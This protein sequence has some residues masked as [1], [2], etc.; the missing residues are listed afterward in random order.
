MRKFLFVTFNNSQAY[1]G[2]S[3]C[4]KRNL[5]T[6]QDI[7][8]TEQIETYIIEPDK[9]NRQLAGTIK[10]AVGIMKGYLGGLT[11]K[12]LHEVL[13]MLTDG[14]FTDLFIDNSQL[15]ML[16]KYAKR[17]NPN[18]RIFTFFHNIEY[19]FFRSNVIHCKDYK[20]FFWIPLALKNE[21]MSCRYSDSII[22]LN[23]KDAKRLQLLYGRKADAI[24][25][26]T[27]K[28]DYTTPSQVQSIVTKGK[29]ALFVG[30]YF[31]GN[32]QGL[33]W[34][35][36]DILPHTDAHLT[37]VGSGMDAFV[38][39]ITVTSQITIH[40]NVPDLTPYYEAA[41]F[42]VLPITTGGGMKVK[43]A[44]ALK[45]GKYIIGTCEAL[46][47]YNV[48]DSIATICNCTN[49]FIQAISRFVS[50]QKFVPAARNLFQEQYSYQASLERFKNI[51]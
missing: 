36:N 8:G 15:G 2:G 6:L 31:F 32:T 49:D 9:E 23:E 34:F 22:V 24:I 51:L 10:R 18:I 48:N 44:E 25:P 37:I 33:K 42:V 4:S 5:Q 35:C 16:A 13:H 3:Q 28:D 46:E 1:S 20:H 12:G 11:D 47:G 26:I 29:E 39:D 41:D 27:M 38:N 40:S 50:G 21:K 7:L 17:H 19:D 30:S 43:T 14:L 45:Y